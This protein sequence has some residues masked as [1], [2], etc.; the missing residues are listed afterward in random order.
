[1]LNRQSHLLVDFKL[2]HFISKNPYDFIS[3]FIDLKV[4]EVEFQSDYLALFELRYSDKTIYYSKDKFLSLQH[5][6]SQETLLKGQ[7]LYL[8]EL[9]EI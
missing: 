2:S 9:I 3:P 4:E 6:M 8:R 5:V 1:M 7:N